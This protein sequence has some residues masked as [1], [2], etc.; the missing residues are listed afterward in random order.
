VR[1]QSV[2]GVGRYHGD[3]SAQQNPCGRFKPGGICLYDF[4]KRILY[5]I[6]GA[7]SFRLK[8]GFATKR[9]Q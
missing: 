4:H 7:F 2:H 5:H 1:R 8:E 3:A 6:E 9:P